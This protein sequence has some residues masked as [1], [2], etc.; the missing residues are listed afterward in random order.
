MVGVPTG[1]SLGKIGDSNQAAK[2]TPFTQVPK[3]E[4]GAKMKHFG[5]KLRTRIFTI[6]Q[7]H[8]LTPLP[9]SW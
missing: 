4:N 6:T 9:G 7:S 2:N 8:S 1:G 3:R 5:S